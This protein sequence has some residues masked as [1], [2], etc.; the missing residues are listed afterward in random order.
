M[1]GRYLHDPLVEHNV[2]GNLPDPPLLVV[3]CE[4]TCVRE[5]D[6]QGASGNEGTQGLM[7]R[8]EGHSSIVLTLC[9]LRNEDED[10]A[11][12]PRASVPVRLSISN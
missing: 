1:R 2:E 12:Q 8:S 10:S 11:L 9:V 6:W 5:R 7:T 4:R 3:H